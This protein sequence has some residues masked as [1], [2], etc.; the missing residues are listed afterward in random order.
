MH[1]VYDELDEHKRRQLG[2]GWNP[3][4]RHFQRS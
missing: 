1:E 3:L 4:P 2:D